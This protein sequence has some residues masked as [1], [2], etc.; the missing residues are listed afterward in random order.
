MAKTEHSRQQV[1]DRLSYWSTTKTKQSNKN[2]TNQNAS[3]S[4][5]TLAEK[6]IDP[7]ARPPNRTTPETDNLPENKLLACE[8]MIWFDVHGFNSTYEKLLALY[9]IHKWKRQ[10]K[11]TYSKV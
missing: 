9:C 10:R 6:S 4:E 3:D 8:V 2:V 7:A 5:E 11:I 1:Q